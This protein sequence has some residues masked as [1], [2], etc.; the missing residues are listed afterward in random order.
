MRAT[1]VQLMT[2]IS[3]IIKKYKKKYCTASQAKMIELLESFYGVKIHKRMLGYHL[4]DLRK[5]GLIKSIR[6]THRNADGTLCLE[7]SATCIT[8][9]G[10]QELWKMGSEWAKKMYDK[11][12]KKYFPRETTKTRIPASV[13]RD[14]LDK[15]RE[16]GRAIFRTEAYRNTFG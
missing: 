13:S 4:A 16:L 9:A 3:A 8:V 12:K 11:L 2:T 14:E 15:R 5:S 1:K 10:Y 6:R 7:T